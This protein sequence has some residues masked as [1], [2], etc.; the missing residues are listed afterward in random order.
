M[1]FW[2]KTFLFTLSLFLLAFDGSVFLVAHSAFKS[3][4][5]S[6]RERSLN[7]HYFISTSVAK[8]IHAIEQRTSKEDNS[9]A[10]RS[11]FFAYGAYFQEQNVYLKLL[12]D[13]HTVLTNL[14][15]DSGQEPEL[16]LKNEGRTTLVWTVEGIKYIYVSGTLPNPVE[17]YTLV[18]IHDITAM[19]MEQQHLKRLLISIS[20][21]ISVLLAIAL[22]FLLRRLSKPIGQLSAAA[23]RISQG[24]LE[25]RAHVAGQDELAELAQH[26]NH[27]ADQVQENILA[28]ELAAEQKQQFIDNLAHEIRTPLT[29]I[30]GYAEYLHLAAIT[31]DDR[32]TATHYILSESKRLQQISFKLLDLALLRH[33]KAE[34]ANVD[35]AVLFAKSEETMRAKFIEKQIGFKTSI[36]CGQVKGDAILLE[37]L[38]VNLLENAIKACE[39]TGSIELSSRI[40]GG[41]AV[42]EVKDNGCGIAQE[43]LVHLTEPF[44]RGDNS[45]SRIQGGAG[46]GL[47]LC[48]QIATSSGASL[49][50][51]SEYGKG[52]TVQIRFTASQQ[53][54]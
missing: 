8:D 13:G 41:L 14:P 15:L 17:E 44:Y 1:K 37:S 50:F 27:M 30:Y 49:E 42:L 24:R 11:L 39:P 7:E 4:L 21:A 16:Q 10:L 23:Q 25:E 52:T 40:E 9:T 34:R 28:L 36:L 26:F 47:A 46:L 33:N 54:D 6:E 5:E 43:Q 45:R 35:L 51:A 22:F 3:S 12:K 32:L 53:L 18:Y 19:A 48:K 31:E 29:A 38:I 2:Q 20:I